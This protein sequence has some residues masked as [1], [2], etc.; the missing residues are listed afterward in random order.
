MSLT[1][2]AVFMLVKHSDPCK[3]WFQKEFCNSQIQC[4][5]WAPESIVFWC[6]C[7]ILTHVYAINKL[8]YLIFWQATKFLCW[9]CGFPS[10]IKDKGYRWRTVSES[11]LSV[12]L[13]K[14]FQKADFYNSVAFEHSFYQQLKCNIDFLMEAISS[15]ASSRTFSVIFMLP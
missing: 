14:I 13:S 11:D 3:C 4:H 8:L 9:V 5:L 2:D 10:H 12:L 7:L 6:H 15:N 1:E